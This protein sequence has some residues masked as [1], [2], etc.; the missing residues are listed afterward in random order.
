MTGALSST[1]QV[2]FSE[3]WPG[4]L[5]TVVLWLIC[6]FTFGHYLA[7]FAYAYVNYYATPTGLDAHLRQ[8]RG[9]E[10]KRRSLPTETS[11]ETFMRDTLFILSLA[12]GLAIACTSSASAVP[13]NA[14]VVKEVAATAS[15]LQPARWRRYRRWGWWGHTKCYREFVIG[16]YSC[17]WFP[18]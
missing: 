17:H 10:G 18:L 6:G 4:I 7:E 12:V 13:I 1:V 9:T 14:A 5:A 11:G 8:T 15:P 2:C 16:P 3:A